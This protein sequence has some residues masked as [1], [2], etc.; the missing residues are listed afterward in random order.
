ML[1]CLKRY[2]PP[3][4]GDNEEVERAYWKHILYGEQIYGADVSGSLMDSDLKVITI[5]TYLISIVTFHP[6]L[7]SGVEHQQIG[8]NPR[9]SQRRL[10]NCHRGGQHCLP[11]LWHVEN[12]LCLAHRGHGPLQY[13]LLTLRRAKELVCHCSKERRPI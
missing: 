10:Q 4:I 13:Q 12:N 3:L 6:S 2:R 5:C 9:L 8:F 7:F 11:L 1:S